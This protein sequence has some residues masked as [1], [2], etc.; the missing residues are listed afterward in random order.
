VL[1]ESYDRIVSFEVRRWQI[2][3]ISLGPS[4]GCLGGKVKD[5]DFVIGIHNQK[6]IRFFKN[7]ETIESD[8]DFIEVGKKSGFNGHLLGQWS[9]NYF[10]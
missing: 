10:F 2:I 9:K 1:T 8:T 3:E 5:S 4:S 7:S 6:F